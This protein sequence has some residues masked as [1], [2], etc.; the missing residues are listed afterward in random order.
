MLVMD[1]TW[2]LMRRLMATVS[3]Q[4]IFVLE[5][6]THWSFY[7]DYSANIVLRSRKDKL[8]PEDEAMFRASISSEKTIKVQ[9]I[10][11]GKHVAVTSIL[12]ETRE[13]SGHAVDDIAPD[14]PKS[15]PAETVMPAKKAKEAKGE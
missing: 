13:V 14:V 5:H 2:K 3:N 11:W 12:Q 10:T 7:M 6:S 9:A 1:V 15:P 4:T 8:G